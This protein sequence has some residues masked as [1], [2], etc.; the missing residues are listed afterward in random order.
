MVTDT[1]GLAIILCA[2]DKEQ[3]YRAVSSGTTLIESCLH[4]HLTEHLNSEIGLG[5]VTNLESAKGWLH[6]SFFFQRLQ[7]NP[8]HY[9]VGKL[10]NQTWEDRLEELVGESVKDLSSIDLIAITPDANGKTTGLSA[11]EY[12]DIMSRVSVFIFSILVN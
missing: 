8:S 5:T 1:E 7:R 6:N 10:Q 11:T 4:L 9:D 12:G 2:S 3:H